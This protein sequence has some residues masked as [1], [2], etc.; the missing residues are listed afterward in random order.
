MMKIFKCRDV[1]SPTRGTEKSAG[2]DFYIPDDWFECV[3]HP[4][5]SV[6]IPSGVHALIPPGFAL[7]MHDKSGIALNKGFAVGAKVID[8]DYQGEIHLHVFNV[9]GAKQTLQPGMKLVQGLL[10]PVGYHSITEATSLKE[11]Y[12]NKTDR[13]IGGFGSTGI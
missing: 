12:K 1:K 11:L 10:I 9:C 13:G 3:V 5:R 4:Q 2:L 6:N 7:I 8:E